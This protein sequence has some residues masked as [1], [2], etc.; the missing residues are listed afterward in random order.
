MMVLGL[1]DL[2]ATDVGDT[3]V[4]N[5]LSELLDRLYFPR[6]SLVRLQIDFE[7]LV[8]HNHL[9]CHR[10]NRFDFLNLLFKPQMLSVPLVQ[11]F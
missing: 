9:S 1:D 6:S 5:F 2:L 11:L 4:G 7:P 3:T 10:G 8:C